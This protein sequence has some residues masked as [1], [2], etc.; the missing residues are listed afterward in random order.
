MGQ[1]RGAVPKIPFLQIGYF[2]TSIL[3]QNG[4]AAVSVSH[5]RPF[6]LLVPMKLPNAV[7][8]EPHVDARDRRRNF[9]V[10]RVNLSR[11][12]TVLDTLGSKIEG[13]PKLRHAIDVGW[14]RILE[15]RLVACKARVLGPR[16]GYAVGS[17]T[18]TAPS[19]G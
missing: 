5:D 1:A 8:A 15:C 9:E 4:D 10:I 3:V 18:L 11:P 16:V 7:S 14:R 6:C 13:S 12:T 2:W 17:V 19:A